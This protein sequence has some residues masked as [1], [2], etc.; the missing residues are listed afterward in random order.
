MENI[1]SDKNDILFN[2]QDNRIV[3]IKFNEIL[4]KCEDR[5]KQ[6]LILMPNYSFKIKN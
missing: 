2:T 6:I 3:K 4:K 5:G 1:G